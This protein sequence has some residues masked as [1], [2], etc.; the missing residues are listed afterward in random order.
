MANRKFG[1]KR[2]PWEV[3]F[4]SVDLDAETKRKVQSW[5]VKGE[6]AFNIISDYVLAGGKF[7]LVFDVRNDCCIASLTSPRS[8]VHGHSLCLSGRGPGVTEAM[9]SLAYKFA[10]ILNGTFDDAQEVAKSRDSWG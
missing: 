4:V 9:R 7:S 1:P 5:D 10:F 3:D 6:E 2:Q 8:E